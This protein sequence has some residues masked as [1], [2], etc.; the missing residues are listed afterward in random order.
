MSLLLVSWISLFLANEPTSLAP[1]MVGQHV[2]NFRLQDFRGGWHTLAE[3]KGKVLI[4][5]FL[6]IECPLV[7]V[8]APRLVELE[9]EFASQGVSVLAINPNRQDSVTEMASFAR[10]HGMEF[11]MLKDVGNKVADQFHVERTPE[12]FVLD[13][14][15]VVRYHG[16]FD[17]QYGVGYIRPQPSKRA[18]HDAVKEVIENK[19]VTM[20]ETPTPGCLIGRVQSTETGPSEITYCK[21][22]ARIFQKRCL[23]C[24]RD[25]QI[26][27]FALSDYQ[28]VAGWSDMIAEVVDNRRMPPWHA[29]P[30][31]G[32]FANSAQMPEDE[33]Q[34]VL[35][36]VK[37][38]AP[39]GNPSD[40]PA[41]V[42]FAKGWRIAEPDLVLEM[43]ADHE[44]PAEGEIP[45]EY[46]VLDPKLT[47]D[48]WVT[49]AE[50][51]PG[52]PAV[53]HHI[54]AFVVEPELAKDLD[55]G[56]FSAPAK[57]DLKTLPSGRK[58][59]GLPGDVNKQI[60]VMRSW[61]TNYLVATAP[62]APPMVLGEGMGKRLR[63]GSKIVFQMHYT[64]NGT[65]QK[66]RS[67]I[68]LSFTAADRI[69]HEVVTRSVLEQRF[70]IPPYSPD[71]EVAGSL[72][73]R[74]DSLL[75]ELF[76]HM[77]LRGKAYRYTALYPDG[78]E[79]ILL[80]IPRYDFGWQNIYAFREP[81][82]MPKGTVLRCT[83]H[84]DNSADNLSNPDPS[85][86]VR[87]GD[88]TWE[89][90]MIG[91]FNMTRVR[92]GLYR[93]PSHPRLADFQAKA[94]AGKIEISDSLRLA[95]S[96]A[97]ETD[98]AFDRW[99][100]GVTDLL[101]QVDRIDVSIA[102]GPNFRY[103]FVAQ[104]E[105]LPSTMKSMKELPKQV[106]GMGPLLGLYQYAKKG[107]VVVN[108]DPSKAQGMEMKF[109]TRLLPSSVHV[110]IK[111]DGK[112]GTV[113][114]WSLEG[115]AFSPDAVE[116][117]RKLTAM[118]QE[119]SGDVASAP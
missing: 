39:E 69:K 91:F 30:A 88:Q 4:V 98:D 66:D 1:S 75:L 7:K 104:G 27:P 44:L 58:A 10:R 100:D 48:K 24:H 2:E 34:T 106:A 78:R 111:I 93:D 114:F 94:S 15:R 23:E 35:S 19:P 41:P 107:A 96:K 116:L 12:F 92:E 80:D 71:H 115:A 56:H 82:L 14:D 57:K 62:G 18:L 32:D 65:P 63:A 103:L 117:A 25:G 13:Q 83:A 102:D 51:V 70:E 38:G 67:R 33:R 21:Q 95:A 109:L 73:F 79:E 64:A 89:E 54:I 6:G 60:A 43:T 108:N 72:R 90:M 26:G 11:P 61:L 17:D 22:I 86:I 8:Y 29:N 31:H 110:P 16:R 55:A 50:C 45:Y 42:T 28:E 49:A 5:A 112:S 36:W 99:W 119:G 101:P 87:F 76:P 46:Y 68:G 37:A 118:L 74:E 9:K 53:V 77:H 84:F 47:E 3:Q 81:K 20:A 85:Q 97:L 59:V 105:E 40:L 113:N 52:N